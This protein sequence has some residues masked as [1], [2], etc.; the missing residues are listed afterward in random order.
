MK[1]PRGLSPTLEAWIVKHPASRTRRLV[2][3]AV[4]LAA[5]ALTATTGTAYAYVYG[6]D[7]SNHQHSATT[8]I[9]WSKVAA[10][11]VKFA[12]LKAT[13]GTSYQ[14]PY[15]KADWAASGKAGLYHGAYHFARPGTKPSV[16]GSAIRQADYFAAY[17]GPQTSWGTLPPVLD[18]ES[19]GGLSPKQL[20]YWTQQFLTELQAKTGRNPIIYTSPY[21]WIDNLNNSTAFHNYPLWVAHYGVK[22]P[23]V[24]GKWP[25]WSFWQTTSSARI[26]GI[27]GNADR[28]AFNG[29]M[30]GLQKFALAYT[31]P[32]TTTTLAA[33]NTAPTLGQTVKFSGKAARSDGTPARYSQ[34]VLQTRAEG[35]TTWSTLATLKTGKYGGFRT[36]MPINAPASYRARLLRTDNFRGSISSIVDVTLTPLDSTITM[37]APNTAL[38]AGSSLTLS[39][40]LGQNTTPLAGRNVSIYS[41]PDGSKTWTRIGIVSTDDSGAFQITRTPRESATYRARYAGEDAY[42]PA[43]VTKG[44]V[45]VT[46]NPT[47]LSLKASNDAPYKGGTVTMRG[48]LRTDGQAV[49]GYRVSLQRQLTGSKAW[50]TVSTQRTDSSGRY[51]IAQ[52]VNEPASYRAVYAGNWRYRAATALPVPVKVSPP[53]PTRL[54]LVAG[55]TDIRAGRSTTLRATL[56]SRGDGVARVVRL[57]QRHAGQQTWHFIYRTTTRLPDGDCRIVVSP[58]KTTYYQLRFHGGNRMESAQRTVKVTVR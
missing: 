46:V 13:E 49:P 41:R 39:G 28:D 35:Q 20:I 48:V 47:T 19:T 18:L 29:G 7:T 5:A 44:P 34:V 21:F 37:D 23:M 14:D 32:T 31:L 57:W 16:R 26:Q 56:T 27:S 40:T 4:A 45:E 52:T 12:F 22:Q 36:S 25:T 2:R 54:E 43:N 33:S 24:P 9:N 8:S 17:I 30:T 51:A 10:D 3:T 53:N 55:R 58:T 42:T 1:G 11:G 50:T 6:V 15:F 38:P